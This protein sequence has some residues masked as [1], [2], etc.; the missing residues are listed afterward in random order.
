M[1]RKA[2][3]KPD[4][5]PSK[6]PRS[7]LSERINTRCTPEVKAAIKAEMLRSGL[8][9]G[10]LVEM[11]LR[12]HLTSDSRS[13]ALGVLITQLS[14]FMSRDLWQTSRDSPWFDDAYKHSC[15]SNAITRLLA[16]LKPK[17]DPAPPPKLLEGLKKYN[18]EA[19][20]DPDKAG[21][22]AVGQIAKRW[23][24]VA[25]DA[26]AAFDNLAYIKAMLK[27]GVEGGE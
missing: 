21:G 14:D 2:T 22:F 27:H 16:R 10:Q 17:G 9:E 20:A 5:R 3:G 4:G 18:M 26:N 15:L 23:D 12:H 6:G 25:P 1:P 24:R 11:I 7:G 8:S 19:F 13:A